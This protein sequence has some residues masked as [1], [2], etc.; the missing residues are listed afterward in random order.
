MSNRVQRRPAQ[1]AASN[2][3]TLAMALLMIGLAII[4]GLK[5][6]GMVE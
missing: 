5:L 6:S 2:I 3:E 4:A 1:P